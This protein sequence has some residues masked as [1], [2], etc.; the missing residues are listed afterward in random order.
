MN[1][2]GGG[3]KGQGNVNPGSRS[4]A[5]WGLEDF[6][7]LWFEDGLRIEQETVKP[8]LEV[9]GPRGLTEPCL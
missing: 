4:P 8:C 6:K 2:E 9:R 3:G 5:L 7:N 1:T